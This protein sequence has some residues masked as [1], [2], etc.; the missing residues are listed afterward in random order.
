MNCLEIYCLVADL[1]DFPI[2]FISS[3]IPLCSKH[4]LYTIKVLVA[5]WPFLQAQEMF[6]LGDCS[7]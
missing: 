6:S 3:L 7:V 5:L 1:G 2:L 4:T